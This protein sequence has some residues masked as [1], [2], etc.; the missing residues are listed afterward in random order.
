MYS[1]INVVVSLRI[2]IHLM[3]ICNEQWTMSFFTP[4][5]LPQYISLGGYFTKFSV[6]EFS[7]RKKGPTRI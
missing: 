6:A 5:S 4:Y 3:M 1:N 7:M 2:A